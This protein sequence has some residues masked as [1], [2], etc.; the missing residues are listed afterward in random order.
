MEKVLLVLGL[1][2]AMMSCSKEELPEYYKNSK[3]ASYI[4]F[5]DV[6]SQEYTTIYYTAFY[7]CRDYNVDVVECVNVNEEFYNTV[8][9][10]N[11]NWSDVYDNRR[12]PNEQPN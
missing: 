2:L 5:E 4:V 12:F 7:V 6:D 10:N 11:L 3:E 1:G 8:D 9:L